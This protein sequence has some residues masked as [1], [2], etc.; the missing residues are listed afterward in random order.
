[1]YNHFGP[2]GNYTGQFSDYYVS[3][4]YKNEWGDPINFDDEHAEPVRDYFASNAA[5]WIEEFHLDGLRLD[6]T[7]QIF[8]AS[9]ENILA[10]INRR[11]RAAAGNRSIVL[12]AENEPQMAQLVRSPAQGGYGLDGIWNDDFHHS[13][14]VALTAANE[15][16]FTDYLGQPQEFISAAKWGF[17]FQG[18]RY[19]WQQKRR[20]T[21]AFDL[22]PEQFI[23]FLENHDQ[24]S[25]SA[26]GKRLC[27]LAS[28]GKFRAMTALLLLSPG[29]PMLFQGQEFACS[30]PFLF[31][32]D[33]EPELARLVA[34]GRAE[35]LCQFPSIAVPEIQAALADPADPATFERCK[36]DL[37]QRERNEA[38]VRLHRDLLRLRSTDPV[39]ASPRLR[40]CDGA[41]LGAQAFALRYFAAD[42]AD[43]LVLVN[44]G[45]NLHLDPAPEPLLAPPTDRQWQVAWS[46]EMLAYG[47]AGAP[48]VETD[49]NWRIPGEATVVLVPVVAPPESNAARTTNDGE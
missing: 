38:I 41:V 5:Y 44:L 22:L 49:D 48:P 4:R 20:G 45:S 19:S 14:H 8:D 18:Q 42:G 10:V 32:A 37:G 6:A 11:A 46:S 12:I 24:V 3:R 39:F 7:Q 40:G 35:F 33:H 15:A 21:P 26:H 16:Y 30:N 1:V 23:N 13:A 25:N 29:T 43:R 27:Y 36:L 2:A 28:P 47:G 9:P 31:F 17:L 34:R